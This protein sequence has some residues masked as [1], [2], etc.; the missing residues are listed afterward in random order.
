M[1]WGRFRGE[2]LAWTQLIALDGPARRWKPKRLRL[3]SFAAVGRIVRS[4]RRIRLRLQAT[5]PWNDLI[6]TALGRLGSYRPADQPGP[7]PTTQEETPGPG[8]PRSRSATA[9]P[10]GT[11]SL[12]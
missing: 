8:E 1:R 5:W 9:G 3:R 4:G 6:T 12:R 2:L 7:A 11:A 10:P